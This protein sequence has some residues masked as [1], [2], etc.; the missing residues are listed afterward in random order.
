MINETYL[1]KVSKTVIEC[2]VKECK[3]IVITVDDDKDGLCHLN[4]LHVQGNVFCAD[5]SLKAIDLLKF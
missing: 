1:R 5:C 2:S 4:I 3:N